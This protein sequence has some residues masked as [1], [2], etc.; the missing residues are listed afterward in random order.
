MTKKIIS[1]LLC[2]SSCFGNACFAAQST[3]NAANLSDYDMTLIRSDSFEEYECGIINVGSKAYPLEGEFAGKGVLTENGGNFKD[4]RSDGSGGFSFSLSDGINANLVKTQS[5]DGSFTKAV[6]I[7][8]TDGA[9][10]TSAKFALNPLEN[11]KSSKLVYSLDIRNGGKSG[12][13][14]S[15]AG[16]TY[17]VNNNFGKL[18]LLGFTLDFNDKS[19]VFESSSSAKPPVSSKTVERVLPQNGEWFNLRAEI[20]VMADKITV[21]IN[22]K[23]VGEQIYG[24][25]F[26]NISSTDMTVSL[27]ESKYKEN[28]IYFDNVRI[29]KSSVSA[30]E[31]ERIYNSDCFD[32]LGSDA[33]VFYPGS[34]KAYF[35]DKVSYFSALPFQTSDKVYAPA[36]TLAELYGYSVSWDAEK[37]TAALSG[38]K[39]ILLDTAAGSVSSD[40]AIVQGGDAVLSGG[41]TYIELNTAGA[42]FDRFVFCDTSGLSMLL[43]SEDKKPTDENISKIIELYPEAS[44]GFEVDGG[45]FT[46]ADLLKAAGTNDVEDLAVSFGV[47]GRIKNESYDTLRNGIK[48]STEHV[49]S[50]KYSGKWDRHHYYPTVMAMGVPSDWT[51]YNSLTFWLYSEVATGEHITVGA[52]SNPYDS[53]SEYKAGQKTT[54]FMYA[55]IYIDFTGW[56]QFVIP[57]DEFKQSSEDCVGFG[58]VD[59]LYFYTRALQYEPY[60]QTVL[61]IDDVRLETLGTDEKA[62]A[63]KVYSEPLVKRDAEIAADKDYVLTSPE[64][65]KKVSLLD[66]GY[67]LNYKKEIENGGADLAQAEAGLKEIYNKYG[68]TGDTYKYSDLVVKGNIDVVKDEDI[69]IYKTNF[70]HSFPEVVSQPK[71]GRLLTQAYFKEARAITGYNPRFL[72]GETNSWGDFRFI[73]TESHAIEYADYEGKWHFYDYSMQIDKFAREKLGFSDYKVRTSGFYD[74]TKLRFD[75]DG[76]AYATIMLQGTK[77]DGS[78]ALYGVLCHSRDNLKTFDFYVLPRAFSKMEILDGH[79]NDCLNGPPVIMLHNYWSNAEDQTGSFVIPE[80]QA[81]GTLVIPEETIYCDEPVVCTSQHSGK[82]NFCQTLGDKVFI[83]YACADS[84][85]EDRSSEAEKKAESRVPSGHQMW[86]LLRGELSKYMVTSVGVPTYIIEYDKKTKKFSDPVFLATAGSEYWDGHNWPAISLDSE[87]KINVIILGHHFPLLYTKSKNPGDISEW[88]PLE[89]ISSGISYASLN[90]DSK[91]NIYVVTR[92]SNDGYTFDLCLE[93]KEKGGSWEESRILKYWKQYYMVWGDDVYLDP[94]TDALYVFF[95]SKTNWLEM[96]ADDWAAR[97][98]IFPDNSTRFTD[99]APSGTNKMAVRQYS[100]GGSEPRGEHTS[101]VSYDYGKTWQMTTTEDYLPKK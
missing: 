31:L 39:N 38:K 101:M 28:A 24:R 71:E 67:I 90:I 86:S 13:S 36:R 42:L 85:T 34:N 89:V 60:P 97:E 43:Q 94:K 79:N 35:A 27:A 100:N 64:I 25:K 99:V 41:V 49:K 20:D 55:E 53:Y 37:S 87:N 11:V 23:A 58:K 48:R 72:P 77:T 14:E 46:E 45:W 65:F 47:N 12:E 4:L 91:D 88:E 52:V 51:G 18:S 16:Y 22:D 81:D 21:Y 84:V 83:V 56:K 44:L 95:K 1:L 29:E 76:D 3:E 30:D 74:E 93:R 59:G 73:W 92:N 70:N 66:Y 75:N 15:D 32:R 50:G 61:Y 82:S 62:E 57:L 96:F 17:S 78:S 8:R 69:P 26:R 6:Q 68:I 63:A 2:I 5:M 40:G 7:M 9:S 10:A 19:L 98:F 80:K 33:L 54:N